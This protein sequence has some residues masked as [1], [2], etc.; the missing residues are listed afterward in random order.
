MAVAEILPFRGRAPV[1]LRHQ[2]RIDVPRVV[3]PRKQYADFIA[4]VA[5]FIGDHADHRLHAGMHMVFRLTGLRSSLMIGR[6]K[7]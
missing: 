3:P 1:S 5:A 7:K 4:E 2:R 6:W